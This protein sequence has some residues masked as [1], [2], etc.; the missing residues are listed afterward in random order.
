MDQAF[1]KALPGR[2]NDTLAKAGLKNGDAL[3]IANDDA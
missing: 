3:H 1:R 2:D